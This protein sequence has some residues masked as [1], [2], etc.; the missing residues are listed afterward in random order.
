M[1]KIDYQNEP[2]RTKRTKSENLQTRR[3]K[4]PSSKHATLY[5]EQAKLYYQN[6]RTDRGIIS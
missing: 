3:K 6:D 2:N 4:T 1:G 5:H